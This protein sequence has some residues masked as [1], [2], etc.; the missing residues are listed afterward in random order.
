VT[1]LISVV[2]LVN[3]F[4]RQSLSI[5]APRFQAEL[6]LTDAG[7]GHVVSLFLLASAVAYALAGLLS[8]WIGTRASMALF[9]GWW[10]AAR[11]VSASDSVSL[12]CGSRHPRPLAKS[13]PGATARWPSACTPSALPSAQS[14]PF[15]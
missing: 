7:Y 10:S 2:A 3:Y 5:V 13:F 1:A 8:D 9:V 12:D 6:H 4:D 11:H 14:P 15:Q